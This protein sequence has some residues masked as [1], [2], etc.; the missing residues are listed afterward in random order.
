MS[1]D[2]LTVQVNLNDNLI[3]NCQTQG[4]KTFL[5][6]DILELETVEKNTDSVSSSP[7]K[8]AAKIG[9]RSLF[10]KVIGTAAALAEKEH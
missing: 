1:L 7:T 10:L 3:V 5:I 4:M 8:A 9:K 2:K 6:K